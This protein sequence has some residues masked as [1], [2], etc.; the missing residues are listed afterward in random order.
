MNNN[1]SFVIYSSQMAHIFPDESCPL[2]SYQNPKNNCCIRLSITFFLRSLKSAMLVHRF[3]GFIVFFLPP[4]STL[5]AACS[6]YFL[7]CA[8][9]HLEFSNSQHAA[10][11]HV[12]RLN[13][14]PL[15]GP[16][17]SRKPGPGRENIPP[18]PAPALRV[19]Y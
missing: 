11:T 8:W 17:A 13:H 9:L 15:P 1:S 10:V 4:Y 2:C 12:N 6:H 18:G 3:L 5:T 16:T 19:T 14:P 7:H